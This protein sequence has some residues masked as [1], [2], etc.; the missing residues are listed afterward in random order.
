MR[1]TR[2]DLTFDVAIGGPAGGRPVLLLHG[3]PQSAR[4]W[5]AVA[6]LL[7]EVGL[8]TVAPDQRGYS[9]GAR[10]SDVAAYAIAEMAADAVAFIDAAGVDQIDVVGHDWGAIVGWHLAGR[11][12]E[13]VR[14]FTAVSVPHPAA[15]GSAI[16]DDPDQQARSAYIRVLRGEDAEQ[17]LLADDGAWLRAVFDGS[18]LSDAEIDEYVAPL[19]AEGALFGPLGWYR[20]MRSADAASLGPSTVPTTYVWSDHDVAVAPAAA[21]GCAQHVTADYRF[22]TYEGVSHW[23]PDT[24]PKRL[25]ADIVSRIG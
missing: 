19:L 13:R 15:H 16:Q 2:R 14:T 24:E 21:N 4:C 5:D 18:G 23:I 12:A 8:R 20:A 3:F 11:H 6:P 25:A 9:P 1:V 22:V 7:H 17:T 10:P